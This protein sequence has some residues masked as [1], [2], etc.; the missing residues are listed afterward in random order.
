MQSMLAKWKTMPE[1]PRPSAQHKLPQITSARIAT[2]GRLHKASQRLKNGTA[3]DAMGWCTESMHQ[4][5]QAAS[6][7]AASRKM[8]EAYLR[9]D[10]AAL[11]TNLLNMALLIPLNK[12]DQGGIRP[13]SIPSVLR[14]LA[15]SMCILEFATR[16]TEYVG[17][18]QHGAAIMAERIDLLID[19]DPIVDCSY[20]SISRTP[21]LLPR[22][23]QHW[24]LKSLL[25]MT[26]HQNWP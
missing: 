9:G 17:A 1:D 22:L 19:L 8:L 2:L 24:L 20:R 15:A 12:S 10:L 26:V 6:A 7:A 3:L 16:I 21:S 25:C 13:I 11:V 5:L 4:M 14:K 23:N 18:S